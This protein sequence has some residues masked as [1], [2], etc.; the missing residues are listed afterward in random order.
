MLVL[1][2]FSC[3]SKQKTEDR[4]LQAEIHAQASAD[5]PEEIAKRASE[6]FSTAQG[7]SSEQKL[8]LEKIYSFVYAD[9]MRIR[10]ELGQSKSLLFSTLSKVDYK[11]KEITNLKKKIVA[12]DQERLNIMFKALEDVQ[13]IVGKGIESEK[14]YKKILDYDMPDRHSRDYN[15]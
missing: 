14:I 10:R 4:E 3:T 5:T 6:S 8:K 1:I 12:L 9:S 7:L 2:S 13:K 15:Y 11:Q